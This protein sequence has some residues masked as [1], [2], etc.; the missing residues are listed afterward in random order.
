MMLS[1]RSLVA[2]FSHFGPA[3]TT[4]TWQARSRR[5]SC[6]RPP[7]AK[8][9]STECFGQPRL[10]EYLPVVGIHRRDDAAVIDDIDHAAIEH[11]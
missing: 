2:S 6:R 9:V 5:R 11:E 4:V 10:L 8:V 7:Q 3:F 1:P